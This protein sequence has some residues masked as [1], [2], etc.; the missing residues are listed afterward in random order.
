METKKIEIAKEFLNTVFDNNIGYVLLIANE[1]PKEIDQEK[2]KVI[3]NACED[4]K[5]A[6]IVKSANE[7]IKKE[8]I[9]MKKIREDLEL[10]EKLV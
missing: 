4:C 6:L 3:S 10:W 5:G 9:R 1:D 8:L 7:V 2:I